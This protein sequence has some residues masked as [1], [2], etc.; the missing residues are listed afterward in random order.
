MPPTPDPDDWPPLVCSI[1]AAPSHVV[2]LLQ[3]QFDEL[4]AWNRQNA[5]H[6]GEAA[7]RKELAGAP[8]YV[9]A[10]ALFGKSIY[11]LETS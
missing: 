7:E 1:L 2:C 8:G 4:Q 10:G 3:P 6:W 9:R 5:G 11:V